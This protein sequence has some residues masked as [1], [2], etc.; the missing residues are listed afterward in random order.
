MRTTSDGISTGKSHS[1]G[2]IAPAACWG[3]FWGGWAALLP[4][5]KASLA[6]TDG[7][8]GLALFGIPI[9]ALPAMLLTGPLTNRLR[10]R[11]LPIVVALFALAVVLPG[12]VN[13][14][15]LFA[16]SLVLVGATSGAIEV[17]LNATT[18]AHEARD[19]ARLFNKVHAATPLA[20]VLAAPAVGLARQCGAQ[21]WQIL[22][23]I[24]AVALF[25]AG[26]AHDPKPWTADEPGETNADPAS[27]GSVSESS[28]S[29]SSVSAGTVL[30]GARSARRFGMATV[31]L[32]TFGLIAAVVLL[33]ENAVEQW[34]AI[35]LENGL[36]TSALVASF[37][38]ASY[39]LGLAVGRVVAQRWGANLRPA[40]LLSI[41]GLVA[42]AGI[43]IGAFIPNEFVALVGFGIAG[44]SLAPAVPTLFSLVGAAAS[45]NRRGTAIST[46]TTISY[47]GFL[48]SPPIVG[49][50]A[51]WLG[52][53]AALGIVAAGGLVV[54]V[55]ALVLRTPAPARAD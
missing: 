2:L 42:A 52:L 31:G 1:I 3:V 41:G 27:A 24:G 26:L 12:L 32:V 6:L 29:E 25:A 36:G 45:E 46:V 30:A 37:A 44:L 33:M 53:P 22:L 28:V 43:A 8:L 5:L 19:S 50:L 4:E 9:G 11:T 23:V 40:T 38:P 55:A 34:G 17:A 18:A 15:I 39:M 35:R 21:S 7:E 49:N 48:G 14:P 13:G 47:L 54:A 10:G 51:G 16:A 20:M